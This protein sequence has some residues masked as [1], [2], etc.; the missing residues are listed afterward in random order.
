ME[1]AQKDRIALIE[2]LAAS[3][4]TYSIPLSITGIRVLLQQGYA[5]LPE[6]GPC[7]E[8]RFSAYVRKFVNST[9]PHFLGSLDISYSI[10]ATH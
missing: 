7:T 1:S 10:F 4:A 5:L 9:F 2:D 8:I 6:P 3:N